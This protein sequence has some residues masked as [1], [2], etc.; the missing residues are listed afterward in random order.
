CPGGRRWPTPRRWRRRPRWRWP[1]ASPSPTP[2]SSWNAR[3]ASTGAPIPAASAPGA[4]RRP[5]SVDRRDPIE[6][7][8]GRSLV[9]R[10]PLAGREHDRVVGDLGVGHQ[11]QQVVD[12][13][14]P[15]PLLAV[16]VDLPP[17]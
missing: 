9:A 15:G 2:P 6:A 3:T 12:A 8:D 7:V 16:A 11:R 10:A 1:S 5:W 4:G 17:R 14:E 13:V